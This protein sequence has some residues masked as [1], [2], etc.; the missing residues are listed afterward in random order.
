LISKQNLT[1][2]EVN[3]ILQLAAICDRRDNSTVRLNEDFLQLRKETETS[4][5]FWYED[6]ELVGYL[7]LYQFNDREIEASGMVHPDH[8][9][10]G[11]FS[12]LVEAL[13]QEVQRRQVPKI[14][15]F[16]EHI[17]QTG[18]AFLQRLGAE[19]AFSEYSMVLREPAAPPKVHGL[20]IREAGEADIPEVAR[21]LS[22]AFD[23]DYEETLASSMVRNDRPGRTRYVVQH[24]GRTVGTIA[25]IRHPDGP[26]TIVGFCVSPAL[27]GRGYGREALALT[28]QRALAQG[29]TEVNLEVAAQNANALRLYQ[30]CGFEVVSAY[31]Y[32]TLLV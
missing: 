8:R 3:E 4:D 12:K 32:H 9:R 26:C 7:G 23:R 25:V 29:A 21:C 18:A 15:F 17:S 14:V 28:I 22:D 13:K 19:Y 30:T 31:D 27:Q 10:R 11:I 16:N 1:A 5:F 24:E 2:A 20:V 6:G